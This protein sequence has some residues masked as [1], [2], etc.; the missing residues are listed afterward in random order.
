MPIPQII[1]AI[2]LDC[3]APTAARDIHVSSNKEQQLVTVTIGN[4]TRAIA[5][6]KATVARPL[7][8]NPSNGFLSFSC[9][10]TQMAAANV[11]V[12]DAHLQQIKSLEMHITKCLDKSIKRSHAIDTESLVIVPG[13]W[14]WNISCHVKVIDDDGN[15]TDASLLAAISALL[16][17]KRPDVTVNGDIVQVHPPSEKYPV[18]LTFHHLPIPATFALLTNE[19]KEIIPVLD[20]SL[21]E[22]K[23]CAAIITLS[24]NIHRQIVSLSSFGACKFEEG[25]LAKCIL[26]ALN[27]AHPLTESIR[28]A[29]LLD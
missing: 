4:T 18:P 23:S 2:R 26:I 9:E 22:E 13:E 17:F 8:S 16:A 3:R 5:H 27:R 1:D 11:A 12:T 21:S 10:I 6:C 15:A 29:A 24:T 14:V 7:P 19:N 25:V 28:Q 20:P